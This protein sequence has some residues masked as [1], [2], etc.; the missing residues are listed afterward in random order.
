MKRKFQVHLDCGDVAFICV[1][2]VLLCILAMLAMAIVHD[3]N[4][5]PGDDQLMAKVR[6]FDGSIDTV[7]V[8]RYWIMDQTI[9]LVTKDG[10]ELT[11]NSQNIIL[12]REPEGWDQ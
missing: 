5:T 8:E 7:P 4:G 9:K 12:I 11:G 3:V 6:Y 1:M 2:V 10:F